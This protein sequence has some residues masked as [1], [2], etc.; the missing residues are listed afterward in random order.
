VVEK[1]A[2][3]P[4]DA[5]GKRDTLMLDPGVLVKYDLP[6]AIVLGVTWANG[7]GLIR[8]LGQAGVPVLALDPKPRAIGLSSRYV[9]GALV[10]PDAGD[11]EVAFLDFMDQLGQ[12]LPRPGVLFL[13]RD[14][15]VSA[16]SRNQARLDRHFQI[17]FAGWQV[18]SRIVDKRGQYAVALD[19]GVPLPTTFFPGDEAEAKL[20]A[21]NAPYPAIIKPAYHVRFS[22]RFG[23]IKGFIANN[24][25]E[26]L[27]HYQRGTLHGYQMMIQEVIPGEAALLYTYG[28]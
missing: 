18:L 25:E 27:A 10:C 6:P 11:E 21:R 4:A 7:L 22:D 3:P 17:P 1:R 16:V 13:T 24:P 19:V 15:D 12:K 28:S 23:G 9:T 14:Q 26:A 20:A 2:E 5:R 8:S